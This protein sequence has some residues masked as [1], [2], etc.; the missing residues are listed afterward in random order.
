MNVP[1]KYFFFRLT[2]LI[3][4]LSGCTVKHCKDTLTSNT[5]KLGIAPKKMEKFVF[6]DKRYVKIT[7]IYGSRTVYLSE[8]VGNSKEIVIKKL[9]Y[10]SRT[11]TVKHPRWYDLNFWLYEIT[12]ENMNFSSSV[13]IY[14]DKQGRVIDVF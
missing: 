12:V 1:Y 13:G 3:V 7:S 14:F 5:D 11:W 10:P 2:F 6:E 9:G 4:S 8:L